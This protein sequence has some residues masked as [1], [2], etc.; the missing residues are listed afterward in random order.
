MKNLCN[1]CLVVGHL[2]CSCP[3]S[4]LK[5]IR[6]K[7]YLG[8]HSSFLH[9]PSVQNT[10]HNSQTSSTT[11][12]TK[13]IQPSSQDVLSTYVNG[14]NENVGQRA[15]DQ[16]TAIGLAIL[17]IKVKASG[18]NR[19]V[20]TYA[21]LYTGSNASFCSVKLAKQLH[22]SGQQST[23]PLTTM[24]NE[25]SKADSHLISLEVLDL[26][27]ENMVNLPVSTES[28]AAQNDIIRWPH[29]AGIDIPKIHANIGLLIGCDASDV[30]E[31]KE[32]KASRNGGPYTTRTIFSWVVNGPLGRAR[33]SHSCTT[34][35]QLNEQL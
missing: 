30:L 1:N 5:S 21:F 23:L 6:V 24:E 25:N 29:F 12:S 33:S 8:N 22:L 31:P 16:N 11:T 19:K 20:E 10:P 3:K 15:S 35:L 2:A 13:V 27:E 7:G 34:N 17:P 14:S 26:E 4:R 32:I 28:I 9:P 18:C